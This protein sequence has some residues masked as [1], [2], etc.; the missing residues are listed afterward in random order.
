MK[1]DNVGKLFPAEAGQVVTLFAFTS[2]VKTNLLWLPHPDMLICPQLKS[3]TLTN[4]WPKYQ[5]LPG[6]FVGIAY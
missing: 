6:C 5:A 1:K 3:C 2:S 4:S